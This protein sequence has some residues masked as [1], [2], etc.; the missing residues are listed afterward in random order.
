[1]LLTC[2]AVSA[3]E[4]TKA[5]AKQYYTTG[6][7]PRIS[8]HDPSIVWE[9]SSQ[10]WYIFG[11]HRGQA[12]T[13]D[14]QQ[15]TYLSAPWGVLNADGSVRLANDNNEPFVTHRVKQVNVGGRMVTFGNYDAL[16]WTR[17]YDA[18][19]GL[20][21]LMWAPDVI[22]N[23]AM[24]KWCMYLSLAG[25]WGANNCVIVL[26]TSDN[27]EGPYVYEGPVVFTGFYSYDERVSY[28]RTDLEL[29]IGTQAVLPAR[30]VHDPGATWVNGID[31]TVFY[32]EE[33]NLLMCY[34]SFFGGIWMLELDEQTGLRDYNVK[35]G[36]DFDARQTAVTLD[37]YFGRK[38]AGGCG[39]TGEGSYIEH[40][41]QYY[42]LFVTHGALGE[43]DG[44][45]MHVFRSQYPQGPYVDTNGTPAVLDWWV[46]NVGIGADHRGEK[47]LGA[48]GHWGFATEIGEVAQGHNSIVAAPDGRTYLVYHT[49]FHD[50]SGVHQVRVHQVFLNQQGWLCAAPFEYTGE[51]TT[52]ADIASTQA[53]TKKE[54]AGTYQLLIH[55]YDMDFANLEQ[56]EPVSITLTERG[57]VTGD[58]TGTWSQTAGTSYINLT[59]GGTTYYGVAVEQTMEPTSIKAVALTACSQSGVNLWAYKM[60]E[61]YALAYTLN[62]ST[63]PLKDGQNIGRN[64]NL[65]GIDLQDN[66][67]LQWTSSDPEHFST[68]G[69]YNPAGLSEDE[70]VEMT[71]K[72]TAGTY[73]WTETYTVNL[74]AESIPNGDVF[75]GL[76]AYYNFNNV[77]IR[78]AYDT[79]QQGK[80]LHLGDGANPVL[81][82]DYERDGRF[83]HTSFGIRDHN[84]FV[85]FPNPLEGQ[86]LSDGLTVA[87]W[88]KP[89]DLNL[90]DTHACF[91]NPETDAT[92][93]T[94]GN[95]YV[96]YR[97]DDD[98]K[99]DINHPDLKATGLLPVGEWHFVTLTL[100]ADE[101]LKTYVDGMVR[102][103][104]NFSATLDGQTIKRA[105]QFDYSQIV[106]H[107][108]QC[109]YFF[110]GHGSYWGSAN[111][112]FDDLFIY[113]RALTS[114][115]VQAL[116]TLVNR[117][118][119]FTTLPT[120]IEE[121]QRT[122][123][124]AQRTDGVYDL[125]GR[126]LAASPEQLRGY[127]GIVLWQGR[128]LLMK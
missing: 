87:Y 65:R 61:D 80:L 119:D 78:N 99:L 58:L 124:D 59:L 76:R 48:Y 127:R 18:A 106:S 81:E 52:D 113:D 14:L 22:Y 40:I 73:Y 101:G 11:T 85:R 92:L 88:V 68:T 103:R 56:V 57:Q 120:G 63:I 91:L 16:A 67:I 5:E 1:M 2:S 89:N 13:K 45:E 15:W 123:Y 9:P 66:V 33:G 115:D 28:K 4:M 46:G 108:S 37:P 53:Y 25:G 83:V 126:R 102:S 94:T 110:I 49:R 50:A 32:D 6:S 62:N 7:L 82:G 75:S 12:K 125:Q 29:A 10:T 41:G 30:Y 84:S 44:Y 100:T 104:S 27:I 19:Q 107:V 74:K 17:A 54:L 116:N 96:G 105:N 109:P 55:K 31:P 79:K 93:F 20:D 95:F 77:G 117:V 71:V 86:P 51:T 112:S 26:L 111:A 47:I 39:A 64:V 70:Q 43:R 122:T 90:Y 128:K 23:N 72:L 34:G 8:V 69:K 121:V 97:Q 36:S 114:Q 60:R 24:K 38:I 35:Y 98:N 21:G 118:F 3:Q 42:Y